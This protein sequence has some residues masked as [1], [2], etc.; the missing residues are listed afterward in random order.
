MVYGLLV[1]SLDLKTVTNV[2]LVA[3]H[4]V[5]MQWWRKNAACLL[6]KRVNIAL[7]IVPFQKSCVKNVNVKY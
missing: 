1:S 6:N 3:Q 2:F 5:H 4:D 7:K